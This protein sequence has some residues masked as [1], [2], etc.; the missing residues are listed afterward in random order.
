MTDTE[1]NEQCAKALGWTKQWLMIDSGGD[2][3]VWVSPSGDTSKYQ[4]SCPDFIAFESANAL[5]LESMPFPKLEKIM[6]P[7][8]VHAL[9]NC[10]PDP[11]KDRDSEAPVAI[12]FGQSED[13]K[14]AICLAYIRYTQKP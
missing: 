14:R 13:R 8:S 11:D 5:L 10:E 12:I 9:W 2:R 1:I 6:P 7:E 3:E 4:W